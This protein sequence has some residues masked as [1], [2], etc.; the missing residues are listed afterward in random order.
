MAYQL[1]FWES[2]GA[3][4]LAVLTRR[5]DAKAEALWLVDSFVFNRKKHL[6]DPF[7]RRVSLITLDRTDHQ[8]NIVHTLWQRS[9]YVDLNERIK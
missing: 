4:D 8:S 9:D 7:F 2:Q 1:T 3:S 6:D 5:V